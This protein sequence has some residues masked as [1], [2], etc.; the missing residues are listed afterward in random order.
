MILPL[1]RSNNVDKLHL[2]K[3]TFCPVGE[4]AMVFDF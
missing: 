1:N 4:T 2:L 3:S